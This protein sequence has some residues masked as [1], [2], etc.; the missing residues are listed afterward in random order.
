MGKY[1]QFK[2]KNFLVRNFSFRGTM[3]RG[4]FWS[5]I[6]VQGIG[7]FC[8][9]IVFAIVISAAVPGSVEELSNLSEMAALIL[10]GIF[11]LCVLAKSRRRLR[12][13]GYDA[14]SYLWLLIPVVGWFVFILRLCGNSK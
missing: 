10:A 7:F 12:D 2:R 8:A 13:A 9:A 14:K 11:C 1:N 4:E 3:E 6:G 5:D